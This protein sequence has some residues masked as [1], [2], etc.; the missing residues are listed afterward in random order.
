MST[1]NPNIENVDLTDLQPIEPIL[2]N[3]EFE[4]L[5]EKFKKSVKFNVTL[6]KLKEVVTQYKDIE[7]KDLDDTE[8]IELVQK[9]A[10]ELREIRLSI[11][12]KHK[13]LKEDSLKKGRFIDKIKN[14]LLEIVL[15]T[16]QV[17]KTQS[18]QIKEWQRIEKEKAKIEAEK[19]V[20]DRIDLLKSLGIEFDQE[21]YS[22]GNI[23][24]DYTTIGKMDDA[25]F[26]ILKAKVIEEKKKIDEKIEA[27]R[28]EKERIE[29]ERKAE[30]D[31]IEA[32]RIEQEKQ[33][34]E[35][36]KQK[37]EIEKQKAEIEKQKQDAQK[38]LLNAKKEVQLLKI[39]A[40][41]FYLLEE[42]EK[43]TFEYVFKESKI[44]IS[45]NEFPFSNDDD[46]NSFL[47]RLENAKNSAIDLENK[48]IESERIEA[49]EKAEKERLEA[50]RLEK[51]RIEAEKKENERIQQIKKELTPDAAY[52]QNYLNEINSIKCAELSSEIMNKKR[53]FFGAKLKDL[54]DELQQEID[55][56]LK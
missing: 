14:D 54:V 41:G 10:K 42:L 50:E 48:R 1:E 4:G 27:E 45:L 39:N 2:I 7:V 12:A 36:D 28:L 35:L 11:T 29:A 9:G 24:V 13:E 26:E 33:Q 20:N 18:E 53:L 44:S 43:T 40:L 52:L 51:E 6:D 34:K 38:E 31:R 25:K 19:K 37:A 23:S 46:L 17:L 49:E 16:E 30:N 56:I 32:Q 3:D 8:S 55:K 15:P 21:L 5:P 22:I 47:E